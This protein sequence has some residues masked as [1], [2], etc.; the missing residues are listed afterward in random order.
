MLILDSHMTHESE[1]DQNAHYS[2]EG[3]DTTD[4]KVNDGH[5]QEDES[6]QT[7]S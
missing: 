5:V 6:K 3:R 7:V 2:V 4:F 1:E